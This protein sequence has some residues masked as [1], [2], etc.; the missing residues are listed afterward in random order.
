[1]ISTVLFSIAYLAAWAAVMRYNIQ[2][3]Q[4]NSYMAPRFFRWLKGSFYTH[5]FVLLVLTLAFCW[6]PC[7]EAYRRGASGLYRL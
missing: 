3:F 1:M 5:G 7:A 4:Q 6:T 2:M